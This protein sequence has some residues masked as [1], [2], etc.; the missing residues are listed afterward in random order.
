[1]QPVAAAVELRQHCEQTAMGV[2]VKQM[3]RT[4]PQQGLDAVATIFLTVVADADEERVVKLIPEV[5]RV[6]I[7][8]AGSARTAA[9]ADQC[10][11]Q[12]DG[13]RKSSAHHSSEV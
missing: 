9:H 13:C 5:L 2:A 3:R 1:M 11:K 8:D 7:V 10:E 6:G 12:R 4:A